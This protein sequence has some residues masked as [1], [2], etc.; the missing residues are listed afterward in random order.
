MPAPPSSLTAR[1]SVQAPRSSVPPRPRAVR[2]MPCVLAIGGL[3]PGGGAGL[4]AD[5]RA[6]ARAGV[7]ASAALAL[8]TI[9][10]T[11]GLRSARATSRAELLAQCNE[12]LRHQRVAVIKI[13]ALGSSENVRAVAE[14]LAAHRGLPAVL[15]TVMIPTRG[16]ARL[17]DERATRT[18]RE[19][20]VPRAA[21][22]TANAP[23]AEALTGRRVTRLDEIHDAA[24]ALLDLGAPA[25]LV[26]GGHVRSTAAVDVLAIAREGAE[27]RFFELRAARLAT[28]PLHGGGCVLA[29]L[30]A[31]RLAATIED[32]AVAPERVLTAAVRWS[33]K[34][35]H[36]ALG[37][38][39]DVGGHLRVLVP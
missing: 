11:S 15:D 7:F 8:T 23:E 4:L 25:A 20:L 30:V 21:L 10:S 37:G 27:P 28:P 33:K 36:D 26:K 3:D 12:V 9:Q 2:T 22:V 1:P 6:I 31:G 39:F 38:P 34:L 5:A 35:H 13:G 14:L 16:S 32:Y 17:L 29:S 18:M 24:S 19:Q